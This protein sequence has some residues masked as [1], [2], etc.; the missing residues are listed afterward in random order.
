MTFNNQDAGSLPR[1]SPFEKSR[2]FFP[3][4]SFRQYP[5]LVPLL[6]LVFSAHIALNYVYTHADERHY[7]D[8]AL[9]MQQTGDYLTPY[10]A[11]G[12]QRF[13]KPILTY[14]LVTL[15]YHFFGV[16]HFSSRLPFWIGGALL[17]YLTGSMAFYVFKDRWISFCA[18]IV[19]LVNPLVFMSASRSIPDMPLAIFMTVSAYGFLGLLLEEKPPAKYYWMAYCGAALGFETKGLPAAVFASFSIA[20]LLFN[21][22]RRKTFRSLVHVP[23]MLAGAA[24]ALSWYATMYA[25]HGEFLLEQFFGDQVGRRVTGSSLQ[26]LTNLVQF[27]LVFLLYFLPWLVPLFGGLR[28][29]LQPGRFSL[30]PSASAASL[31]MLSWIVLSMV[32]SV[33][34]ST[35]FDRYFLLVLPLASV[36]IAYW[37]STLSA[38]RQYR[39]LL[40]FSLLYAVLVILF[41]SIGSYHVVNGALQVPEAFMGS[42]VVL[43][44]V[45]SMVMLFR[46]LRPLLSLMLLY[47]S[48][49]PAASVA[50]SPVVLPEVGYETKA[51]LDTFGIRSER[52]GF[53]G[54]P[55]VGAR[56]RT[57][58]GRDRVVQPLSD[59]EREGNAGFDC[60]IFEERYAGKLSLEGY[61]VRELSFFWKT[62]DPFELIRALHWNRVEEQKRKRAVKYFVAWKKE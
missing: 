34:L 10:T 33:F 20:F 36:L 3:F 52:I 5:F 43:V 28:K 55:D 13:K 2:P 56:I 41:L 23:S 22:W 4:H 29:G 45:V 57:A 19:L 1:L 47:L 8:A 30:D 35:F 39:Y 11:D 50:L 16:S 37:F 58:L 40:P 14:W 61:T 53:L 62:I 31:F 7:T 51:A 21:P 24:L 49:L 12:E 60:I 44:L 25:L 17:I 46:K 32:M 42:L 6:F 59:K 27:V 54:E 26:M 18:M 9:T 38:D 48:L 15:S